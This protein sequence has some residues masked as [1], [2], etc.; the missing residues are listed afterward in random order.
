MFQIRCLN[1]KIEN[2]T[3]TFAKFCIEPLKQGQGITIGN[4]LRRVLLSDLYGTAIV[5]VRI[6]NINHDFSTI[7]GLKEDIIEVL[8]NLKQVVLK[9]NITEPVVTRL[10]FHGPGIVTAQDIKL[11]NNIELVDPSQYIASL[12]QRTSLEM[13]IVIEA[14]QGYSLS[15]Q[16]SKTYDPNKSNSITTNRLPQGFLAIDAVFMPVRKVN[17]FIETSQNNSLS[18]IESLILEVATNGSIRPIEALTDA[19]V[20][21]ENIFATFQVKENGPSQSQPVIERV[22]TQNDDITCLTFE[23]IL[24]EEL[25]LSVRAYNCLKRADIHNLNDL[26]KY[27][28]EE[29]LEFKN[30]GQK[31]FNEVCESLQ[32]RYGIRLVKT[33]QAL[34]D[35]DIP[36]TLEYKLKHIK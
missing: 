31:S 4:A 34:L 15:N 5:G 2:P 25:E 24:L 35:M 30:F 27:S 6:N 23:N 1:S 16:S 18:T 13:E 7:P 12:T 28:E 19:A 3:N 14:G 20:I 36:T 10:V 11:P 32:T 8:L 26:F 22:E 17:F 29:L 21:L 33:K 9:G